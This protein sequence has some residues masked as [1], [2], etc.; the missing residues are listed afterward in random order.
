MTEAT[1]YLITVG[2]AGPDTDHRP[3]DPAAVTELLRAHVLPDDR[4]QHLRV[5]AGPGRI[6]LAAFLLADNEATALLTTRELCLR[7]LETGAPLDS[8][9][10]A[11]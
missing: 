4:I 7:A 8:W 5:R 3:H 10:L 6:D 1:L 2:L 9:R 11:D